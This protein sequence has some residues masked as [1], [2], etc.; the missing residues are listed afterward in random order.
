MT[1][2]LASTLEA[3]RATQLTAQHIT[4]L[5]EEIEAARRAALVAEEQYRR[6]ARGF[7]GP[8]RCGEAWRR[9]VQA[10][11]VFRATAERNA[12]LARQL[13]AILGTGAE[14]ARA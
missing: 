11:G 6:V 9:W 7:L 12:P 3:L 2:D 1:S 8:F 4:D 13:V 10:V 14:G 5:C